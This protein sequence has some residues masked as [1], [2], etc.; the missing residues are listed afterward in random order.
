MKI[1]EG[2]DTYS[3]DEDH[4]MLLISYEPDE[5]NGIL[6][7][8]EVAQFVIDCL[9]EET[10]KEEILEKMIETYEGDPGLMKED[11]D[12]VLDNLRTVGILEE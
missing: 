7:S 1:K 8:N 3:V 12:M 5:F 6:R 10:S 2:Y 9:R 4:L 11:I